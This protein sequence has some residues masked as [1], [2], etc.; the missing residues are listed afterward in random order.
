MFIEVSMVI[1]VSGKSLPKKQKKT[2]RLRETA[3]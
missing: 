1:F 3:V 2:G